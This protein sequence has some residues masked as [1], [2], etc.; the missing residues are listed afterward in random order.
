MKHITALLLSA[1]MVLFIACDSSHRSAE[2]TP[3]NEHHDGSEYKTE[4]KTMERN[5]ED[6]SSRRQ[7]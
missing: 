3:G 6:S 7:P 5:H 2:Q 4:K 1:S